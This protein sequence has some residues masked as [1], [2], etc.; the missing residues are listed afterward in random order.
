MCKV[1]LV[2]SGSRQAPIG[3]IITSVQISHLMLRCALN[4]FIVIDDFDELV[5]LSGKARL[6][7]SQ[8]F[9]CFFSHGDSFDFECF[10]VIRIQNHEFQTA[11]YSSLALFEI[12]KLHIVSVS[13]K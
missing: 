5:P 4:T 6:C 8:Y 11:V 7:G 9:L 2:T 10:V 12:Y 13:E 1:Q 3:Q